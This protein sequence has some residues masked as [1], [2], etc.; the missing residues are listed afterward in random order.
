MDADRAAGIDALLKIKLTPSLQSRSSSRLAI[1]T[2]TIWT[3]AI[4]LRLPRIKLVRG[5]SS[6]G[7]DSLGEFKHVIDPIT[8]TTKTRNNTSKGR[9]YRPRLSTFASRVTVDAGT[10]VVFLGELPSMCGTGNHLSP[11]LATPTPMLPLRC[12]FLCQ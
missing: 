6:A 4:T 8:N 2:H 11:L 1:S 3:Q 7:A 9:E 10:F 12:L 5:R